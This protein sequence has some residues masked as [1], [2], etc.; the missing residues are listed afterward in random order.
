MW[1]PRRSENRLRQAFEQFPVVILTGARQT[2]KTSLARRLLPEAGYITFD[3][4]RNAESARLDPDR[5]LAGS[6]DPVIL[7][8]IQYVPELFPYLK[9]AVD[10]DRR[11]GRFFL[12]GSQDFLLM[13]GV[14]ESLAGRA[15]IFT[16]PPLALDEVHPGADLEAVD[17]FCWRGGFPELW[18]RPELDR[19]LWMGSYFATYLERDVRNILTVG[20]LRDFD[21][22]VRAAAARAGQLLSMSELARDVGI[23]PNTAKNWLSVLQASRQVLL[24]EPYHL[25]LGKRLI[26]TPKLYFCD[27]GFLLYLMGFTDW[28]SVPRQPLWGA[29]WENFVVAEAVKWYLN[30]GLRP[31]TYF[32][33]T[34]G[35]EEVD[36]VVERGPAVLW[37]LECK[38]S[39][40]VGDR[41]L[42]GIRALERMYGAASVARAAVVCRTPEAYP[43]IQEGTI[44]AI[45]LGGLSEWLQPA[46][47]GGQQ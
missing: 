45:P 26:K 36:L 11:P 30:R 31:P 38:T 13:Q 33:R 20:S 17:A 15:A 29:I 44:Q 3:I 32:W 9:V 7:D 25:S 35:G 18:R 37:A 34:A 42:K 16:L 40:T 6:P 21:R 28:A 10:A 27:T 14:T 47:T 2:G 41:D 43:L 46:P 4:P 1:I 12:T 39:V 5:F 23:S 19:E 22:F 8:E 24:L